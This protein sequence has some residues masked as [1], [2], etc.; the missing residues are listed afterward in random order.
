M[1][2]QNASELEEVPHA[3]TVGVAVG[4]RRGMT[5]GAV[6][7][8]NLISRRIETNFRLYGDALGLSAYAH[9]VDSRSSVFGADA[10]NGLLKRH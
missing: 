7:R 1:E 2:K 8:F 4:C 6:G 3:G 9:L 5:L 10:L